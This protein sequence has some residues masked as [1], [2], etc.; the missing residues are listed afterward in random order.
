[1]FFSPENVS[2]AA[3]AEFYEFLA[4]LASNPHNPVTVMDI[5][6][7]ISVSPERRTARILSAK[8]LQISSKPGE[9]VDISEG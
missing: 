9:A 3:L 1:M 4:F 7:E 6:T 2:E 8:P 5:Q